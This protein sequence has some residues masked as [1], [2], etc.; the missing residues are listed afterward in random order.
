MRV[1]TDCGNGAKN[2]GKANQRFVPAHAGAARC[3]I[4]FD[5]THTGQLRDVLL[6]QPDA[7]GAGNSLDNQRRFTFVFAQDTDKTLLELRLV[8]NLQ[9]IEN[10]R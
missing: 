10:G 7:G 6:I 1:V 5:G 4:D 8:K 2:I 3:E 9:A